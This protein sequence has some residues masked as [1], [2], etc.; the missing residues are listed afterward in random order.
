MVFIGNYISQIRTE[1]LIPI[2]KNPK[3]DLPKASRVFLCADFFGY[4]WDY[5]LDIAIESK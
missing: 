3:P 4:L 2:L 5:W 1:R